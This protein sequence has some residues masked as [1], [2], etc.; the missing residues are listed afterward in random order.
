MNRPNLRSLLVQIV[1]MTIVLPCHA[2]AQPQEPRLQPIWGAASNGICAGIYVRK[3]DWQSHANDL[4]CETCV[5]NMSTNR[6]WIWVPPIENRFELELRGPDGK[7]IRQLKPIIAGDSNPFLGLEPLS[8]TNGNWCSLD[9]Y[10]LRDTF[11]VRTN[12]L[13]TLV[14]SVRVNAFTN[15]PAGRSVMSRKPVY[16]LTPPVTNIVNI[17][18]TVGNQ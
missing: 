1:G 14:V 13:H 15:F 6:L 18:S 7:R 8:A 9:W 11:D 2:L 16:F 5:R 3:S 12:G 17:V 10:F 4:I